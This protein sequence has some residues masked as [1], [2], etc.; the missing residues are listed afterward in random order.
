LG[1]RAETPGERASRLEREADAIAKYKLQRVDWPGP[2]RYRPK[3]DAASIALPTDSSEREAILSALSDML[4]LEEEEDL[5]E[6][7]VKLV[8]AISPPTEAP[9][10]PSMSGTGSSSSGASASS[11]NSSSSES[12]RNSSASPAISAATATAAKAGV[13]KFVRVVEGDT[14]I[15]EAV[16]RVIIKL[17]GVA[18][19]SDDEEDDEDEDGDDGDNDSDDDAGDDGEDNDEDHDEDTDEADDEDNAGG[20]SHDEGDDEDGV[21]GL[22]QRTIAKMI[23][24]WGLED[25]HTKKGSK[26]DG[27]DDSSSSSSSDSS[28]LPD[29]G[30][31]R[32]ALLFR[33]GAFT[34]LVHVL[35]K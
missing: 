18:P 30:R 22:N 8:A 24:Q 2:R 32:E 20:Y 21:P 13:S 26:G 17:V 14:A 4:K 25:S 16:A 15:G 28:S 12:S 35:S 11:S 23:R 6:A 3:R 31:D 9:A 5:M 19:D 29:P 27:D 33:A 10:A 1:G 34:T 7:T